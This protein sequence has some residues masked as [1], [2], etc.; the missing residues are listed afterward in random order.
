MES[1]NPQG[2]QPQRKKVKRDTIKMDIGDILGVSS[3]E[4]ELA[5]KRKFAAQGRN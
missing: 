4:D 1:I 2:A 5:R 3:L